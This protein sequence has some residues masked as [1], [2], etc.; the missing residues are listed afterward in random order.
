MPDKRF[1]DELERAL[2]RD[3]ADEMIQQL[4]SYAAYFSAGEGEWTDDFSEI[5]SCHSDDPEKALAY[6]VRGASRSDE[7]VLLGQLACG[8]PLED[9]L[10]DPPRSF[11]IGS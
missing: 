4:N 5:I 1:S 10:R 7:P 3:D 11:W 2:A 6:V 8:G 9:V